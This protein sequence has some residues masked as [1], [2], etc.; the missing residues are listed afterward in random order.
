[1]VY[2]PKPMHTQQAFVGTDS[3]VADCPVTERLC[4]TVLSLPMG[5]Y[6]CEENV[7]VVAK[8]LNGIR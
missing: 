1:M 7:K 5:P 4:N 8:Y 2:Y 6:L 3:A